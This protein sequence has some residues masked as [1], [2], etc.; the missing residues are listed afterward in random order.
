M[1]WERIAEARVQE[2]LRRPAKDR[3]A[4]ASQDGPTAPLEVQLLDDILRLLSE[5]AAC[6]DES[7]AG[8][9][10]RQADA[11]QTRLL[12]VLEGSGRPLAAQH[13]ARLLAEA[14]TRR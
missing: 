12:I 8:E 2:W 1:L 4:S 5:A 9:L 14:R 7:Q 11:L 13:F 3:V 6:V 10:R